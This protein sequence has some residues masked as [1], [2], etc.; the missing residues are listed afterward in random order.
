MYIRAELS[1]TFAKEMVVQKV[2]I[3]AQVQSMKNS[4]EI[5]NIS[6]VVIT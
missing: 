5:M 3:M 4:Q 2:V 1:N 6:T